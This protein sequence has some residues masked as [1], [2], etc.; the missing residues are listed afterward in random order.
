MRSEEAG[1]GGGEDA[2][3]RTQR[4]KKG[5]VGEKERESAERGRR[6]VRGGGRGEAG[7][8]GGPTTA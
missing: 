6:G 7:G 4:R 8:G 5:E 2:E 3:W 1:R